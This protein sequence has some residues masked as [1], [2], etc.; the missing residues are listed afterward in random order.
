MDGHMATEVALAAHQEI[1]QRERTIAEAGMEN[2]ALRM[3]LNQ[4]QAIAESQMNALRNEAHAYR[5]EVASGVQNIVARANAQASQAEARASQAEA[6]YQAVSAEA[7]AHMS[8]EKRRA[9]QA[10]AAAAQSAAAAASLDYQ[11]RAFR[12]DANSRA[13]SRQESVSSYA[14]TH[15]VYD[16]ITHVVSIQIMYVAYSMMP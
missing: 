5:S 16:A 12:L 1:S 13:A 6:Q 4:T 15:I 3:G 2:Q 7:Q 14:S 10:E 11:L 8:E 9:D